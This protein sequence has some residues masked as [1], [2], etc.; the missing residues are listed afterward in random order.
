MN[1]HRRLA[2]FLFLLWATGTTQAETMPDLTRSKIIVPD[3]IPGVK[4]LT[5]EGLIEQ[6][7]SSAELIIIDA[8]ISKDR[9]SGYIEDSISLPD[10][11]TNC[12]TLS[13]VVKNGQTPLLFYCN[14]V[15]CGRSVVAIK[16]AKS[17][18]YKNLLW[19]RGGFEEWQEKGYQYL[20][21]DQA[22][23]Q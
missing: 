17:C 14:G 5:A 15:K 12:D 10:I 11:N 4:T 23:Q 3:D 7:N 9:A 13:K 21:Q 6:A 8:R 2:L 18:G 22:E 16:I 19:F 20:T 1:L